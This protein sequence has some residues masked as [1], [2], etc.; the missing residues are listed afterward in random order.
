MGSQADLKQASIDAPSEGGNNE[1]KTALLNP[2]LINNLSKT[3]SD[4]MNQSIMSKGSGTIGG[5][6]KKI[7][8]TPQYKIK[9]WEEMV[10]QYFKKGMLTMND[11]NKQNETINDCLNFCQSSFIQFLERTDNKEEKIDEFVASFN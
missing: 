9:L 8:Y 2:Q 10:L 7:D 6:G 1:S 3:Q 11:I 4:R 5:K